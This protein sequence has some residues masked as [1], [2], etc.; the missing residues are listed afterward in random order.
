MLTRRNKIDLA[1]QRLASAT[2]PRPRYSL[3]C[4]QE[5][6][7]LEFCTSCHGEMKHVR[8]CDLHD[9]CTRGP[10]QVET[11][12]C[13]T[14]ASYQPETPSWSSGLSLKFDEYSLYPNLP[15]KRFNSSLIQW[16]GGFVLC[17]RNGWAG[18][19]LFVCR[20]NIHLQPV[21]SAVRLDIRHPDCSYGREDP[22]LFVYQNQLHVSLTG[23]V[24]R[25]NRL[26]HTNVL[27]VRLND[28]LT[29]ARVFSPRYKERAPSEKNWAFFEHDGRLHCVYSILPHR[30]LELDGE[31]VRTVYETQE[32]FTWLG[33]EPRGGAPPVRVGNEWWHFCHDRV[34]AGGL[35]MYRTLLYAFD[36]EP[37]FTIRRYVP[38]PL[39]AADPTNKP[40]DQYAAVVWTAGAVQQN[41]TWLLCNGIHDR[42]TEIHDWGH[43][44]LN[45]RLI[46]V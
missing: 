30:V 40:S 18:S 34:E 25:D 27:Y 46:Q 19:D 6:A 44:E 21:G 7:V 8:D 20:M 1:K 39:M 11:A 45:R 26:S 33:G 22:R 36:A 4:I 13:V 35:R 10:N 5:G 9:R 23:V 2:P 43:D 3:P 16:G 31:R 12:S 17:W 24:G 41:D 32:Q 14:C 42:W 29:V 28:D 15:G 38:R 37:P